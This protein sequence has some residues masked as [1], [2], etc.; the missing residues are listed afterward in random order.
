[1]RCLAIQDPI[2]P[3]GKVGK[4]LSFAHCARWRWM[5]W[6]TEGSILVLDACLRQIWVLEI[7]SE[8]ADATCAM[9]LDGRW[10]VLYRRAGQSWE[11]A[12]S[13]N[14][15]TTGIGGGFLPPISP[16]DFWRHSGYLPS[17]LSCD[18]GSAILLA[19]RK[20]QTQEERCKDLH[21]RN[22]FG[23]ISLIK[24][25]DVIDKHP[26]FPIYLMQDRNGDPIIRSECFPNRRRSRTVLTMRVANGQGWENLLG[27]HG[28]SWTRLGGWILWFY[29]GTGVWGRSSRIL[30]PL[31][32]NIPAAAMESSLGEL[33][34]LEP[35]QGLHCQK[36]IH[37][38]E[39]YD[40]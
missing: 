6:V 11:E 7:P 13:S 8:G 4:V 12:A 32:D 30:Y 17:S 14:S 26:T 25:Q 21:I 29:G 31:R 38:N 36:P 5:L 33:W 28:F 18:L 40:F 2:T 15:I 10:G 35:N 24:A 16:R 22:P 23:G 1:M 34:F 37:T 20:L 39:V 27:H 9:G 19:V 3:L